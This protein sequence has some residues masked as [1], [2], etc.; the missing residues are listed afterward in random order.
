MKT[1]KE[2]KIMKKV[3]AWSLIT[4]S[5]ILISATV[6]HFMGSGLM[7]AGSTALTLTSAIKWNIEYN[8]YL[9]K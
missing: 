6:V 5:M 8:K 1:V 3:L 9:N 7:F 4:I 2:I